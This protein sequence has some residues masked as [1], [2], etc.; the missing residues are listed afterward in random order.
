MDT[1]T[2]EKKLKNCALNQK[3][4][5]NSG[6][7]LLKSA[8]LMLEQYHDF[9][10]NLKNNNKFDD[11]KI[12]TLYMLYAYAIENFLK[13]LL[14]LIDKTFSE[15]KDWKKLPNTLQSHN[16]YKLCKKAGLKELASEFESILKR[17]SRSTEWYGR[18]PTP[19]YAKDFENVR[20]SENEIKVI[21]LSQY[22]SN[23]LHEINYIISE[24]RNKIQKR[25]T[26]GTS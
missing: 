6:E 12:S 23:D 10:N 5:I 15:H 11:S 22:A 1:Q 26:M 19:I 2:Y 20:C 7:R 14:I 9:W 13:A 8:E 16:L 4:W 21:S 17:L 24:I 25:I 3:T 18:Y